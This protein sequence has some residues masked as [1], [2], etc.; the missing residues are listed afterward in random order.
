[1]LF[2]RGFR[3]ALRPCRILVGVRGPRSW[4]RRPG[5]DDRAASSSSGRV[6]M[7]APAWAHGCVGLAALGNREEE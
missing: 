3:A 2:S 6:L 5:P 4:V 1:R 7:R